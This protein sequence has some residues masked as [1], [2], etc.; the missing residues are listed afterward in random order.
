MPTEEELV[1]ALARSSLSWGEQ[2]SGTD[3]GCYVNINGVRDTIDYS[4]KVDTHCLSPDELEACLR[5]IEAILVE[6]AF[7]PDAPTGVTADSGPVH[8]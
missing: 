3:V 8:L 4:M 7:N 5:S 2:S 1:A 6:A